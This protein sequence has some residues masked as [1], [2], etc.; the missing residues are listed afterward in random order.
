[1]LIIGGDISPENGFALAQKYLG[2]WPKPAT[3][4]AGRHGHHSSG[5]LNP[6]TV[7]FW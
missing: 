2:D 4:F 5:E 6:A 3:E 1:V 7:A